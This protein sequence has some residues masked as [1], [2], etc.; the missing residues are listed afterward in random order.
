MI[1]DINPIK[2]LP[3]SLSILSYKSP[4]DLEDKIKIGQLTTIPLRNSITQG[5]IY[6][7]H[8]T[9][10]LPYPLKN[11][12]NLTNPQP[13]F[14]PNQL[15]LFIQLADYY[16][17]SAS[18]FVHF[19]LPKLIK[20]DWSKLP[21]HLP[22]IPPSKKTK[23]TYFWWTTQ[24][25]RNKLYLK[26]IKKNTGQ[27]LIIV[28][29]I[30]NIHILAKQLKLTSS[31]YLAIHRNLS[32]QQNFQA[33]HKIITNKKLL[34]IGTRSSI[35]YPFINLSTILIDNEHSIDHKQY[36]MNPR[37]D[38]SIVA[39]NIKAKL[40]FSSPSPS[41]TSYSNYSLP[42]IS[43]HNIQIAD[44][45]NEFTKKNYSFISDKLFTQI[46][47]TLKKNK[48][49]FLFI[50]KKGESSTTICEDCHFTFNCPNC[51]LPFIKTQ[52]NQLICYSCGQTQD[53]PP[54]C[55]KCS[56]PNFKSTGLG[57]Q[58]VEKNLHQLFPQAKIIR[59]DKDTGHQ[60]INTKSP[61]IY[62]GTQ[63]ALD[64]I[65]WPKINTLGIIN[66]DQ[67]WHH[68]E[69]NSAENAYQTIQELLTYLQKS[70]N[71]LIQTFNP[72]HYIIKSIATNKP[73][74]FYTQ[75]L[76]FRKKFDYPPYTSL[77]KLSILH[78][79]ESK[80]KN[81]ADKLYKKIKQSVNINP[82]IPI[83][84]RKIRGK[85]KY[86]IILKLTNLKSFNQIIKLIPNDWLIDIHPRTLLD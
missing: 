51:N 65:P 10:Q 74:T 52:T 14:T 28:P 48:S 56:G 37:Y 71:I 3:K 81:S 54:F 8:K 6:H 66:A 79:S 64:K 19:N 17:V 49:V 60:K 61:A 5:V 41:V 68:S 76:K 55:P 44:L 83:L 27:L 84:R 33:W 73:L 2:K 40:I 59:L 69:F 1:L 30:N 39:Q 15:K 12:I 53:L 63:F 7:I 45:N 21:A 35:F 26:E 62:I 46:K 42:K 4:E 47:H 24:D 50:N 32:R 18:L 22:L 57:I 31:D 43:D 23:P 77:I 36:D 80:A 16:H 9:N 34:I 29:R 85:Y 25:E 86:N 82:P 67:L 38:V 13:I 11:I 20:K 78:S 72:N 58:K 70:A 75:E